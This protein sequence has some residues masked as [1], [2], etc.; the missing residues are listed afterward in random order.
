MARSGGRTIRCQTRLSQEFLQ[1]LPS[2]SN[3]EFNEGAVVV[4]ASEAETVV[5]EILSAAGV[6]AYSFAVEPNFS[7][8]PDVVQRRRKSNADSP[9]SSRRS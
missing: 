7:H 2:V 9:R 4:T 1:T 5:R 3:V 8:N 6:L